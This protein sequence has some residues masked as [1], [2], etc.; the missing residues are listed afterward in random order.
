MLDSLS[1][2]VCLFDDQQRLI[3]CNQRWVEMYRLTPAQTRPG[4]SLREIVEARVVA[5]TC[6]TDADAY[7]SLCAEIGS[8]DE[9]RTWT[10]SLSDG[11]TIRVCNRPTPEG[12]WAA[13]TRTSRSATVTARG[14][15]ADAGRAA[16]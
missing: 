14:E 12:G 13:T 4:V 2:G 8:S 10:V 5:G 3:L 1:L 7:L 6:P 16:A 9:A 15:V 11:R